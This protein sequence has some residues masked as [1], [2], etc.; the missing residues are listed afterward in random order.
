MSIIDVVLVVS[1]MGHVLM[2]RVECFIVIAPHDGKDHSVMRT[3]VV[4][5]AVVMEN[6]MRMETH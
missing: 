6:V 5:T 3:G 2:N 4:T 1:T